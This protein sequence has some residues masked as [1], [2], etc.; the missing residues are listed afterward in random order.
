M[1][2]KYSNPIIIFCKKITGIDHSSVI[3]KL[4]SRLSDLNNVELIKGNFLNLKIKKI[5]NKIIVY[6]VLH[7]LENENEVLKFIYKATSLLAPGGKILFGDIP[8]ISKK[9]RFQSSSYG[10]EFI[11]EWERKQAESKN[12]NHLPNDDKII[13]FDDDFILRI[14]KKLRDDNYQAYVLPQPPELPF[15]YS[16]EDIL[17][18]KLL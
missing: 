3:D 10:K 6:S 18:E 2:W 13:E 17:L 5:Y 7:Y 15:G 4:T 16:R 11:K 12:I 8:N 1:V 14:L 9:I